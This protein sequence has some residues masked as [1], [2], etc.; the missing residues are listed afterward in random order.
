MPSYGGDRGRLAR[1]GGGEGVRVGEAESIISMESSLSLSPSVRPCFVFASPPPHS[2]GLIPSLLPRER[3]EAECRSSPF[4]RGGETRKSRGIS[5][6]V[7]V[8]SWLCS[9]ARRPTDSG[10]GEGRLLSSSHSTLTLL[11]LLFLEGGRGRE[12][13]AGGE[14]GGR[15]EREKNGLGR[16]RREGGRE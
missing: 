4:L 5:A 11:E 9:F 3:T 10:G 6:K 16:G 7:S 15:G 12:E 14:I 1:R 13:K 8:S 2:F